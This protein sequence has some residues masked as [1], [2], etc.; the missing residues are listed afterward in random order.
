MDL[1]KLRERI[2]AS[3]QPTLSLSELDR[4]IAERRG[5]RGKCQCGNESHPLYGSL[6]EDCYSVVS[7][8]AVGSTKDYSGSYGPHARANDESTRAGLGHSDR[9]WRRHVKK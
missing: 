8:R 5:E 3:G 1:R 9:H 6:C 4:E 7:Q 2:I